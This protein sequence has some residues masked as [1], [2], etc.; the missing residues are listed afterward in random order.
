MSLHDGARATLDPAEPTQ[1][2]AGVTERGA[3]GA[4][5]TRVRINPHCRSPGQPSA[6]VATAG[7]PIITSPDSQLL[8]HTGT[9]LFPPTGLVVLTQTRQDNG[10]SM[11]R[12]Q[13]VGVVVTQCPAAAGQG[14]LAEPASPLILP[15]S[16][17]GAD[18]VGSRFQCVGVIVA[19]QGAAQV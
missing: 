19:Q 8:S 18:N 13:G 2:H 1:R 3:S 5:P 17:Q 9:C 10:E 6:V 14:V 4:S 12:A 15:Q 11:H 16:P 7:S